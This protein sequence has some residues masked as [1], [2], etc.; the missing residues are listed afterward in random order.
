MSLIK[1]I[2]AFVKHFG[3]Y[4]EKNRN[5]RRKKAGPIS[6]PASS[7]QL[8]AFLFAREQQGVR[9]YHGTLN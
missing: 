7:L 2:I 4:L 9:G 3:E 8:N 5:R 1:G 6:G